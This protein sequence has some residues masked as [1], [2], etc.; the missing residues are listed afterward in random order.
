MFKL[1]EDVELNRISWTGARAIVIL[2]LLITA[3]RSFE[4]IKSVLKTLNLFEEGQS[5]DILRLDMNS[6]KY[7]GCKISRPSARTQNKYVLL[8]HPYALQFTEDEIKLLKRVYR[9]VKKASDIKLLMDFD[10][11]FKKLATYVFNN[12]TK[13]ALLGISELKYFKND[14]IQDLYYAAEQK[15]QLDLIYKIPISK[16]EIRKLVVAQKLI[17]Q[18]GKIYLYGFDIEKQKSI[19]LNVKRIVEIIARMFSKKDVT[20]KPLKVKFILH[21]DLVYLLNIEEKVLEAGEKFCTVEASYYNEFL[22]MQRILSFGQG[23]KVL[24]P[25]D[26]KTKIIDK[27]KEMR[28]VYGG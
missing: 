6:L 24:E 20:G 10:I 18:N 7:I 21:S 25:Q 14:F 26:F 5:G 19:V 17:M 1:A 15:Y 9:E 28:D 16:R 8:D 11:F 23:C 27:L 22:A 12:E 2:G 3:P 13:E 4:E